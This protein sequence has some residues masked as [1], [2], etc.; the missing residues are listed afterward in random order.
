MHDM[1]KVELVGSG[2][3]GKSDGLNRR[4]IHIWKKRSSR[5]HWILVVLREAFLVKWG[6]QNRKKGLSPKKVLWELVLAR[7]VGEG[8][9]WRGREQ[10]KSREDQRKIC[11]VALSRVT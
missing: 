4:R 9:D 11:A 7:W 6:V 3:K 8:G 2:R 10:L 1:G 5:C